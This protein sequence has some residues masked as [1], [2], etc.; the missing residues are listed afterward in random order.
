MDPVYLDLCQEPEPVCGLDFKPSDGIAFGGG[1]IGTVG[2]AGIAILGVPFTN[3][4]GCA[5]Q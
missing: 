3:R 2:Y 4:V 1:G 5:A